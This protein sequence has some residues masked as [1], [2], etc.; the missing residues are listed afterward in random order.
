MCQESGVVADQ[1]NYTVAF[2]EVQCLVASQ[3]HAL[4]PRLGRKSGTNLVYCGGRS[5]ETVRSTEYSVQGP[6]Y[7][8]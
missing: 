7:Q 8:D 5:L 1:F 4:G 2:A 3:T 6:L